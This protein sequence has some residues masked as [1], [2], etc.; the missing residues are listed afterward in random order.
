MIRNAPMIRRA[1]MI[2]CALCKDAPCDAACDRLNPAELLR[3][4]WFNN[5]QG[6]AWRLPEE[7]PCM[8]CDAPCERA[9]VRPGEVPVRR[10]I[11]RLCVYLFCCGRII[12]RRLLGL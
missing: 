8:T 6:A 3:S 12:G 5:E 7:N 4:L 2:R 9:C 1:N 10:L 11:R